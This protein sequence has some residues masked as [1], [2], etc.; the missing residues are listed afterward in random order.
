MGVNHLG[1]F[2][3]THLLLDLLKASSPSR[4]VVVASDA[5]KYG[6]INKEDFNS[7][8]QTGKGFSD[9]LKAYGT[10][11]IANILFTRELSKRLNRTGIVV[12]TLCPGNVHTEAT[13]YL[14][15]VVHFLL[16]TLKKYFKK[17][18]EEGCQTILM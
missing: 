1:H 3:L 16:S 2:L 12:N 6:N 5:H 10:S 13:R 11:K 14:G 18:P 7:E 4:I 8:K 15:T 17:T 9:S